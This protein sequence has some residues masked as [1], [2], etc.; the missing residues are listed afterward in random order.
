MKVQLISIGHKPPKWVESGFQEYGKR[1]PN[2]WQF[3]LV[4][5]PAKTPEQEAKQLL[6][7]MPSKHHCILLDVKG[8]EWTTLELAQQVENWQALG[9]DLTFVI[10]GPDGF[11]P[12]VI[13]R[14]DQRWSLS[15]LTLPHPMVRIIF[16][17]QLYRA[18][19]ITQN[20]PY[21]RE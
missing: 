2:H 3:N 12:S 19:T 17:E 15:K 9:K 6:A 5:L 21:H 10:G 1:L 4:A 16:I 20:H 7:K 18:W 8:K 14:A 11:D 13:E